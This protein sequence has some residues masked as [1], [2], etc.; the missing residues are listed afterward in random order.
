MSCVYKQLQSTA[1][2]EALVGFL[3]FDILDVT[4]NKLGGKG[5]S[6]RQQTAKDLLW[7][8]LPVLRYDDKTVHNGAHIRTDPFARMGT[9]GYRWPAIFAPQTFNIDAVFDEIRKSLDDYILSKQTFGNQFA[10]DTNK[11]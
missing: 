5:K 10:S 11:K 2:P 9:K 4:E 1:T 8:R 7:E 6:F 3:R